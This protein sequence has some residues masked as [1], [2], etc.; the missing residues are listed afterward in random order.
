MPTITQSV[1]IDKPQDVVEKHY[2]NWTEYPEFV[3]SLKEVKEVGEN[4][5]QC[6]LGII[7]MKFNYT[8][9]VQSEGNGVYKW[10]TTEG[11]IDHSGTATI[12]SLGENRSRLT[13][14]V[15]YNA[16]GPDIAGKIA[17]WLGIADSGLRSAM[18]NFRGY[19]EARG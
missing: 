14:E 5:I 18:E 11:D 16:P 19:V 12:E 13:L 8:A 15:N 10:R 17:N 7:G 2:T 6:Q 9:D 4:K 1:E 3:S